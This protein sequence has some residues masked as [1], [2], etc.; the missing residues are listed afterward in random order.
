ME[1]D[2]PYGKLFVF[3]PHDLAFV[4]LSGYFEA[5]REAVAANNEGMVSSRGK[6]VGH[7]LEQVLAVVLNRGGFSVHHAVIHDHIR[8]E[9]MT[10][11][12]MSEADAQRW[13]LGA[14]CADNFVG[15]T[16]FA[17]RTRTRRDKDSVGV[18][19]PNCCESNLIISMNLHVHA[20][21]SQVLHE[22]VR[23]RIVVIDDQQHVIRR[24]V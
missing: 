15:Q 22:V 21:F 8:A 5:V 17:R 9:D 23:E 13:D 11:A 12:L 16:R 19:A 7:A 20:H 4:G 24:I 2:T 10:D 6:W 3:N 1:L 14:E 18:Q